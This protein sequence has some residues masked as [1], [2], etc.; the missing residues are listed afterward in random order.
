MTNAFEARFGFSR[1]AVSLANWRLAP[2]S[3]WSFQNAA[4]LVPSATIAA[5][6]GAEA[7]DADPSLLVS[8]RFERGAGAETIGSFLKRSRTDAL[9]VMK[10]GKFVAD[11]HAPNHDPHARH[12]VYSIS[13]SLTAILAGMLQEDG[14]LDPDAPITDHVPEVSGSAYED[15]T[16]RHLLDM[17]VA[18]D[19]DESYTD[20][21]SDFARYRRAMLWNPQLP[22]REEET[23]LGF[24]ASLKKAKSEHGA[25]FRYR[26][27]NSDLLGIVVERASGRRYADL[28]SDRLWKP[29]GAKADAL[30]TV[31]REGTARAAGGVSVTARDLVRVGEL[32]RCGGFADGKRVLPEAWLRDT[33]TG[34][35]AAAWRQGDFAHL[36]EHGRYRNKWYQTGFA[37]GAFFAIGIHGQWLWVD[38]EA[39]VVIVRFSS[40]LEP[41]D[42]PLDLECIALFSSIASQVK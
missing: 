39:A 38:P 14:L 4:E 29:V 42:D 34:G 24:L 27:P 13:K 17:A 26:S 7:P 15:A 41:V 5:N 32:M 23:M 33:L 16:I 37:N 3:A 18:L 8:E 22:G 2:Y 40:Q 20:P 6:N 12:I 19:F 1:Q 31:D 25:P 30:V 36:L 28:M 10:D 21:E 9:V 35:D 11:F